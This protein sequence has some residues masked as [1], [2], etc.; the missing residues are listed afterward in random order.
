MPPEKSPSIV[1]V[2]LSIAVISRD[3]RAAPPLVD[4]DSTEWRQ[5][6]CGR[7]TGSRTDVP[8]GVRVL[9]TRWRSCDG[10]AERCWAPTRW[11]VFLEM[12]IVDDSL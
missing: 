6:R 7:K 4:A 1:C 8:L 5:R 11:N 2:A 9:L 12:V 10:A 3:G